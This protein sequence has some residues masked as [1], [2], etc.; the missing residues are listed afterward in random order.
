MEFQNTNQ[1]FWELPVWVHLLSFAIMIGL[2]AHL[3]FGFWMVRKKLPGHVIKYFL[4]R[5]VI[6]LIFLFMKTLY[7]KMDVFLLLYLISYIDGLI[8]LNG[9][10]LQRC[11]NM[12]QAF[13]KITKFQT[14]KKQN[15]GEVK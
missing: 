8:I 15:Y 7:G 11:K 1:M 5:T 9:F 14:A 12:K 6:I 3:S 4:G 10:G 2:Y 13:K